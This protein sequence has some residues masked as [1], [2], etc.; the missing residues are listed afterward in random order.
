MTKPCPAC[1]EAEA[2]LIPRYVHEFA[3]RLKDG[4]LGGATIP[5]TWHADSDAFRQFLHQASTGNEEAAL[6]AL[7]HA[8][9]YRPERLWHP[10]VQS[11][12]RHLIVHG[13]WP[14]LPRKFRDKVND[15]LVGL[16]QACVVG[17]GY[18]AEISRSPRRRGLTPSLFPL[19]DER[20][21]LHS[22]PESVRHSFAAADF[23]RLWED[24]MERLREIPWTAVRN[25]YATVP[26]EGK[27]AAIAELVEQLKPIL[28]RFWVSYHGPRPDRPVRFD[29]CSLTGDFGRRAPRDYRKCVNGP[30]APQP[31]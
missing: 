19:I 5:C 29:Y 11:Q 27:E 12:F 1:G 14:D 31:A 16:I 17:L 15:A 25:D 9:T 24:L 28:Q 8:L 3:A 18:W 20:E 30:K 10:Y 7:G 23:I 6:T 22:T 4:T 21:G 26:P 2:R 13:V